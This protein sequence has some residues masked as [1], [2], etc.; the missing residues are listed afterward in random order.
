MSI[1][2]DSA[3][4][5]VCKEVF[6]ENSQ[7][8]EKEVLDH[9]RRLGIDP[10]TEPHLLKLA[11]EG[12][13]AALPKGWTP[14]FDENSKTFYYHERSTNKTTWNH[15]LDAVYKELVAQARAATNR[16]RASVDDEP[17]LEESDS[18]GLPPAIQLKSP[19]TRIPMKL[20]PLKRHRS[21]PRRSENSLDRISRTWKSGDGESTS[22]RT[23][24]SSERASRD[25]TNLHFQD[26]EFY[27]SPRALDFG[28]KKSELYNVHKRSESLSPRHEADWQSLSG[29]FSSDEN[30]ID[31]NNLKATIKVTT[32]TS[33]GPAQQKQQQPKELTLSG[34]GSIFLKSNRS[35][36]VTPIHDGPKLLDDSLPWTSGLTALTP[37]SGEEMSTSAGEKLKS[38][39]REKASED[40]DKHADEERKSVRFDLQKVAIQSSVTKFNYSGSD[41]DESGDSQS[42]EERTGSLSSIT[43][44][45]RAA[46][47]LSLQQVLNRQGGAKFNV[48][49]SFVKKVDVEVNKSKVVARRFVVEN[50]SEE[51]HKQQS[52]DRSI[53]IDDEMVPNKFYKIKNIDLLSKSDSEKTTP[54]S[55]TESKSSFLDDLRKSKEIMLENMRKSEIKVQNTEE[56]ETLWSKNVLKTLEFSRENNRQPIIENSALTLELSKN[57]MMN[58]HAEELRILKQ[59]LDTKIEKTK[60]FFEDEFNEQ[61]LSLEASIKERLKELQKEMSEKEEKEI[62]KLVAYMDEARS[63]NLKK[64]K[65]ELEMCYE[66]E[67]QDILMNLKGE[68]DQRKRELLEIRSQE[69]TKLESEHEKELGDEKEIVKQHNERIEQLKKELDAEFENIRTELN[70]RKNE[71]ITK[72]KE[73]HEKILADI[74]REFRVDE[75]SVRKVY[76]QQLEQIRADFAKE[77]EKEMKNHNDSAIRQETVDFEKLRCEKRLLEDKYNT[78]K[79]KYLKMKKDMRAA[80]EKRARRKEQQAN[81]TASETE[82]STSTRT[83]T[84]R[85]ESSEHKSPLTKTNSISNSK[86][87]EVPSQNP[88]A[89]KA[90]V[91]SQP[92]QHRVV[93]TA[94]V[95]QVTTVASVTTAPTKAQKFESD[96]TT[97]CSETTS[98]LM[99]SKKKKVLTKKPSTGANK[100]N[101]N[102]VDNP[103]ENIRKQL[104]QLEDIGDQ[105]PSN[106][107]AYTVRYPFQDK[108]PTNV[109]SELE[110]FR[111]R[112]HVERDSV[113]RAREALRQQKSAFQSRQ[114][115]WKQ[116]S[117]RAT[118]EQLVKEE[119]ELSDMEVSLHRTRSLLGEK[120]IHLRHLEQSLE[121]V[122]NARRNENE[123]ATAVTKSDDVTLSD[124]SSASSGFSSTDLGTD[125]FIDKYSHYQ[126][127][128]EII[129]SLENLNSEIREIWG[130]LNKRQDGGMPPPPP[131]TLLYTDLSWFPYQHLTNQATSVPAFG[132]P[133]IQS[134][135]L[136]QLTANHPP[137]TTQNIIAQYGPSSG[138][139]T[140]VGTVESAAAS[141]LIE[142]TRNLKDWLRQARIETSDLV[143]PG[144]ATL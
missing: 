72:M 42:I 118:L 112:I 35:R 39:L 138:Y 12:L 86:P 114:R 70:E 21:E 102:L 16:R 33:S 41:E 17:K 104:E 46:A 20:A 136:S 83:R 143:S 51:E 97:T 24:Q 121:R 56:S 19:S 49:N 13:M 36:D 133:N 1:S 10:D 111:H 101:N 122:A 5:I 52:E 110:F 61:K 89:L 15:P 9:A 11:R 81:M 73:E 38:I 84:E 131:P 107:T 108:S 7:P 48:S 123:S 76:K 87:K 8:S 135:L 40:D 75:G 119:R 3:S 91:D 32:P 53:D 44:A 103:V 28:I 129:A 115:A 92:L 88:N 58:E 62:Q 67:R 77:I 71:K 59:E 31:V 18:G 85:T 26:P 25:Y 109:P 132:T 113:K 66:K 124:M 141:S 125:T 74:V 47:V 68:L 140:S 120:I 106:E 116:R 100:L 134:N 2:H 137:G 142:R 78:L 128:T 105:L 64:V 93:F 29:R 23:S 69:I 30:I 144:Q 43:A 63:E 60:K 27:E 127:S 22:G 54:R 94:A 45:K 130:V 98:N 4:P 139:T 37:G 79:E 99:M 117:A 6:D 55:G 126:E 65:N 80:I 34:G 50:V 82:M 95:N 96:D 57:S 14:L 90:Q